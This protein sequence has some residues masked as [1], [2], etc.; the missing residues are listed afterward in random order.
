MQRIYLILCLLGTILPLGQFIPWLAEHGFHL[1]LMWQQIHTDRLSAFAWS[2]VVVSALALTVFVLAESRRI[3]MRHG[4]L[5]LLGL[6]V[7]VSMALPLFLWLRQR[8]LQRT[9]T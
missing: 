9:N 7:G 4:P 2:D 1:P 8:Y 5:A 6:V 3:G